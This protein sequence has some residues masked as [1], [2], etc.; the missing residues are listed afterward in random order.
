MGQKLIKN[1]I[2]RLD[3]ATGNLTLH[4][5]KLVKKEASLAAFLTGE[6]NWDSKRE[7]HEHLMAITDGLNGFSE[8]RSVKRFLEDKL[9]YGLK[10]FERDGEDIRLYTKA[11]STFIK[12]NADKLDFIDEI[13]IDTYVNLY[14][15]TPGKFGI[16]AIDLLVRRLHELK[17]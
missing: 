12:I 10:A 6:Q 13:K 16:S 5:F 3:A 14:H 15:K 7:L 9:C 11:L 8:K 1:Q 17:I 2:A 4:L